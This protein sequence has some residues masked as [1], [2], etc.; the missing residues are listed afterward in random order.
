MISQSENEIRTRDFEF[1]DIRREAATTS[2]TDFNPTN[3]HSA[4]SR[5]S[6]KLIRKLH[7]G[8]AFL[9][10]V[11]VGTLLANKGFD[12]GHGS[13]AASNSFQLFGKN[14]NSAISLSYGGLGQKL[15]LLDDPLS[16]DTDTKTK[17]IKGNEDVV[18]VTLVRNPSSETIE[19]LKRIAVISVNNKTVVGDDSIIIET[20]GD[21]SC[22]LQEEQNSF[23]QQHNKLVDNVNKEIKRR[24]SRF[25]L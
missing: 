23:R 13:F 8:V 6:R 25:Q 17:E 3:F 5:S 9:A 10:G 19:K 24:N 22:L 2:V 21:T 11:K 14:F 12:A 4:N 20:D 16:N 1:P 7:N 18:H 15:P